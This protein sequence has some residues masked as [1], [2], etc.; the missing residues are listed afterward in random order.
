MCRKDYHPILEISMPKPNDHKY[1]KHINKF[2]EKNLWVPPLL[3]W[4]CSACK[5][6]IE[7]CISIKFTPNKGGGNVKGVYGNWSTK[8]GDKNAQYGTY[9]YEIKWRQAVIHIGMKHWNSQMEPIITSLND[10]QMRNSNGWTIQEDPIKPTVHPWLLLSLGFTENQIPE[11]NKTPSKGLKSPFVHRI[12]RNHIQKRQKRKRATKTRQ[13]IQ[14]TK[15]KT[16]A[17][18]KTKRKRKRKKKKHV[19]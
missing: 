1:E 16:K 12:Q 17:Q 14:K 18:R 4:I 3:E 15:A 7:S 9:I 10:K 2:K 8:K 19:K 11:M 6:P 5:K 13:Q